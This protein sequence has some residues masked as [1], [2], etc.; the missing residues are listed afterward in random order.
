[1]VAL[2]G[3][4]ESEQ[5][6]GG[7]DKLKRCLTLHLNKVANI[8]LLMVIPDRNMALGGNPAVGESPQELVPFLF[9]K[10]HYKHDSETTGAN[11]TPLIA[12]YSANA[13]ING[14]K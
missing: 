14:K 1:M 5:E 10:I 7:T 11:L 8:R 4:Y 3:K 6:I 2:C 13:K 12:R 9:V